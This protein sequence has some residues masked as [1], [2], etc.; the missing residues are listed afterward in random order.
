MLLDEERQVLSEKFDAITA[1]LE[2]LF[3]AKKE[4]YEHKQIQIKL[5][6][7]QQDESDSIQTNIDAF[8]QLIVDA[9][10]ENNEL[11][12]NAFERLSGLK[13]QVVASVVNDKTKQQFNS[14]IEKLEHQLDK[15]PELAE[16]VANAT[17]LIS[18]C[19]VSSH[20][21]I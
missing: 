8:G 3:V 10:F 20:Q 4:Q 7:Q 11:G 6:Q 15:L 17:Q 2:K 5:A 14:Q 18:E 16:S 13:Q 21:L 1:N 19:R 9:V 12:D